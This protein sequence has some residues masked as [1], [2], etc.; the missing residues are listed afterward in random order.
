LSSG[1]AF[2]LLLVTDGF[3]ADTVARVDAALAALAPGMA[4]V[5][6][7]AKSLSGRALYEAAVALKH[8]TDER[9]AALLV[10]D[11]VDVA[12]AIGAAGAHLPARGLPPRA[13]RRAAGEAL[14]L[15][16]STHSLDELRMAARGGADYVTFGPVFPTASKAA[17]G[18]PVG[19]ERLAEGVREA[20]VPVFALGGVDADRARECVRLGA[21][22][23]CIGAVLGRPDAAAG[24]R[25]LA[26]AVTHDG[27]DGLDGRDKRDGRD[28]R[29]GR[30][31][32]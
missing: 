6:L 13:A 4:A 3:D 17:F 24:A 20:G 12:R 26:A 22:V 14:L 8:V 1:I 7:R 32:A 9:G 5:Q 23:A 10:N 11:R 25:A 28:G 15:G 27:R 2:K 29:D 31:V 16:A 19:L 30:S 21:R 18:P